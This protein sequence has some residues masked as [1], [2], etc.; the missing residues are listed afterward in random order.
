MTGLLPIHV[1][2]VLQ[3]RSHADRICAFLLD[4]TPSDMLGQ[5]DSRE[6]RAIASHRLHH[7]TQS[8]INLQDEML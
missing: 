4:V 8:Y 2:I 3:S 5:G 6:K 1:T 7:T